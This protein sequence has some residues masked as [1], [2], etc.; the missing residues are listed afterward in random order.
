MEAGRGNFPSID[1]HIFPVSRRHT[2]ALWVPGGACPQFLR[3]SAAGR[4][5]RIVFC[6]QL[7]SNPLIFARANPPAHRA[8]GAGRPC[9]K[10]P[11]KAAIPRAGEETRTLE[12]IK[13]LI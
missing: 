5:E 9:G 7:A 10:I 4:L 2:Y 6:L 13:Y 12:N 8:G 3:D 1:P 11:E